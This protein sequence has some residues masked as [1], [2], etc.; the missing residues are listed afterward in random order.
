MLAAAVAGALG[1]ST[2]LAPTRQLACCSRAARPIAALP[3]TSLH[4]SSLRGAGAA[5]LVR[6]LSREELRAACASRSLRVSGTKAELAARLQ[7]YAAKPAAAAASAAASGSA[8]SSSSATQP[9]DSSAAAAAPPRRRTLQGGAAAPSSHGLAPLTASGGSREAQ[10]AA[11]AAPVSGG[12]G[13]GG[14]VDAGGGAG[15]GNT[16]TG[17]DMEVVVLGSGACN[18]SPTRSASSLAL[19]LLNSYW[20]FDVGEGTQ[21]QLQRCFVAPGRIDRFFPGG[22]DLRPRPDGCWELLTAAFGESGSVPVRAAPA[23]KRG[24]L[25]PELVLPLL[26][27]NKQALADEGGALADEW[28]VRDPRSVL[29]KVAAL[30]SEEELVLPDGAV[31]RGSDAVG[32][33]R[34]GRKIAVL[35]DCCDASPCSGI[36]AGCD[37]LV[38]EATDAYLQVAS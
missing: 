28:G 19:R 20:L 26:Q 9:H 22:L 34:R 10:A 8:A 32:G 7:E 21:V 11:D 3:E 5:E 6:R 17:A 14:G 12:G 27:R 4:D 29:K 24:R 30:G 35:G 25:K 23:S 16:G 15:G 18:P 1:W 38:H 13:G 33:T 36:A 2:P 37:L 31:I